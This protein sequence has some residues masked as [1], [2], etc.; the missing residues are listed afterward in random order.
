[1]EKDKL[2]NILK[3]GISEIIDRLDRLERLVVAD[4]MGRN[5]LSGRI[6]EEI[7]KELVKKGWSYDSE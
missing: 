2:P 6:V 5:K 7:K 1:M 3:N 4:F